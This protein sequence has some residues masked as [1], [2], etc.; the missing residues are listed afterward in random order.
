MMRYA[1]P[2]PPLLPCLKT[3][4]KFQ[5]QLARRYR[6]S[7]NNS[8]SRHRLRKNNSLPRIT[9]WGVIAYPIGF[10][11]WPQKH[12]FATVLTEF[13]F[14]RSKIMTSKNSLSL[15]T[16]SPSKGGV[17]KLTPLESSSRKYGKR[18]IYDVNY[19]VKKS[20]QELFKTSGV[21]LYKQYGQ[22]FM[23]HRE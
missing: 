1:H 23:H 22:H 16:N 12:G 21:M 15:L 4:L 2:T 6:I 7:L 19:D 3:H 11:L 9:P 8:P 13:R 5:N 14:V 10:I 18:I 20:M 17:E